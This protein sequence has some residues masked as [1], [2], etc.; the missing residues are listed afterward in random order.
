MKA[1]VLK[2][3]NSS[4]KAEIAD[5]PCPDAD[6][7]VVRVRGAG[8]CF[9]DIKI[10][11]GQLSGFITLPL[12][13]G[14]EVAGEIAETGKNVKNLK[15][16]QKGV[17]YSIIGCGDCEYC[18]SGSENLCIYTR[19]IGFEKDG[20]FAEYVKL[21]AYNFCPFEADIPFEKMAILPDA[22]GTPY[23]AFKKI[24]S[25]E[26][27]QYVLIVGAGGLGVHAVQIAKLRGASV[28]V[29]DVKDDSLVLA[30][31]Y[32]ADRCINVRNRSGDDIIREILDASEGKGI[33]IVLE[34]VGR[35]E[36]VSW[37]LKS[38]KKR[39]TLIV[40]GYDALNKVPVSFIDMH[41]NE[42]K[43]QGTKITSKQDLVEVIS[44][45]EKGLIDPVV[46]EVLPLSEINK[47]LDLVREHKVSGRISIKTD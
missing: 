19:R 21:P 3:Y 33:D 34:G 12:I 47:G 1:M 10:I 27:G 43:I 8:M 38:L 22:A 30:E 18:R 2:E 36:T 13:P 17:V 44:L 35:E 16:G 28:I 41:N 5:D 40:M 45:V 37:S 29:C 24:A 46:T 42:W 7:V 26:P 20:G 23:H 11:T 9:T 6:E 31:K 32:G 39:G 4:L 15:P 25:P 14:H